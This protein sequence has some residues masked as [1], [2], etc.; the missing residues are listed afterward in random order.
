MKLETTEAKVIKP[1]KAASMSATVTLKRTLPGIGEAGD[2]VAQ[3]TL[4]AGVTTE[5]IVDGIKGGLCDLS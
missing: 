2:E 1:K 4:K 3:I 5:W